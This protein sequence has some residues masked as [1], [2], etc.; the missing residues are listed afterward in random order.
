MWVTS[1]KELGPTEERGCGSRGRWHIVTYV[2]PMFKSP[3]HSGTARFESSGNSG[4]P[5]T[6]VHIP[7]ELPDGPESADVATATWQNREVVG[8][9]GKKKAFC[10]E[11]GLRKWRLVSI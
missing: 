3:G 9:Q 1:H 11:F 8:V 4:D 5:G 6:W 7:V 10:R 2:L